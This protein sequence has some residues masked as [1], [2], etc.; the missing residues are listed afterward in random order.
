MIA[1]ILAGAT[2]MVSVVI[3]GILIQLVPPNE[4][5]GRVNAAVDMIFIGTSVELGGFESGLTAHWFGTVAA[6]VIGGIGAIVVTLAW[7]GLFPRGS[8]TSF[9]QPRVCDKFP[10][11]WPSDQLALAFFLLQRTQRALIDVA[12]AAIRAPSYCR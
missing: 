3:R 6:V 11:P 7:A 5:R 9:P 1:L 12:A 10:R 2:D 8:S 4:M